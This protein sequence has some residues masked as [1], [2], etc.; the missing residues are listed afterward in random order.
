M[1]SPVVW[2]T[3]FSGASLG[4]S[5]SDLVRCRCY[6]RKS[7]GAHP[8]HFA[9]LRASLVTGVCMVHGVYVGGCLCTCTTTHMCTNIL[10]IV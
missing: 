7:V 1:A 8:V 9:D 6:K 4:L 5:H 2:I 10:H 3:Q